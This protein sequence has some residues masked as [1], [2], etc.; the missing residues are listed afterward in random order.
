VE[1]THT[2]LGGAAVSL[3]LGLLLGLERQ[4][5]KHDTAFAGIRTIPLFALSGFFAG[6][7]SVRGV[8]LAFPA[9]LL[10][11]GALGLTA[12]LRQPS[13]ESGV[14]TE[15]AALFA[16]L[17]GGV[18]AL[19]EVEA[20][21]AAAVVA[22]LLLTL[23]TPLHRLAGAVSEDEILA[24]IKFAVVAVI[25][26]PLLPD[27]RMGPYGAIEPRKVGLLVVLLTGISLFGYVLVKL[28]GGRSGWSLAGALGGLVSSTATTLSFSAKARDAREQVPA[29]AVGI[30]LA[31]TILYARGA[32]VIAL[33]DTALAL[34]LL[35]RLGVLFA[36]GAV[37]AA[38]Q[39]RRQQAVKE[40]EPVALGN[41]VELARAA[42]LAVMFAG[43]IL[44][45]RVAQERLGTAGLWAVGAIGGL[46]DVDSVAVASSRVRQDASAALGAAGGAY[47]LATVTN[48]AFKSG[49]VVLTGGA[50]LGRRVLPAFAVLGVATGAMLVLWK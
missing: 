22:T 12:Y 44:L 32:V 20:A 23:K 47:L 11:V 49:A 33:L 37:F 42:M 45:A 1:W 19:G 25:L 2:P 7:A 26:L 9:V 6:L 27:R 4:R 29:L 8:P 10:V 28:L 15:T 30:I 31:S 36:I 5:S 39:Y 35:P 24:I 46:V 48:L 34:Y 50:A 17:L 13:H 43:V 16:V 3:L 40:G 38:M 14:T 18:V 41:P 21:S